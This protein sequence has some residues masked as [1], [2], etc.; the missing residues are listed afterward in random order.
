MVNCC[1]L[2]TGTLKETLGTEAIIA[3]V[4]F[5]QGGSYLNTTLGSFGIRSKGGNPI[6]NVTGGRD[7]GRTESRTSG[8]A[9]NPCPPRGSEAAE[10]TTL[11]P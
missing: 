7:H 9:L 2:A 6:L 8:S 4:D 11:Y 3:K 10:I 1:N 5:G